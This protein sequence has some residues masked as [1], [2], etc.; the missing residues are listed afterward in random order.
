MFGKNRRDRD[1]GDYGEFTGEDEFEV[2]DM[3][4]EY[5]PDDAPYTVPPEAAEGSWGD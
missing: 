1:P 5:G 2:S 4:E 3:P